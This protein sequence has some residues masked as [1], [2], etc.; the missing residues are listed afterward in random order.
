[1]ADPWSQERQQAESQSHFFVPRHRLEKQMKTRT[2]TLTLVLVAL[3][4]N[5]GVAGVYAQTE[6]RKR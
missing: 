2:V 4:L 5:L 1:M 3:M 6:A